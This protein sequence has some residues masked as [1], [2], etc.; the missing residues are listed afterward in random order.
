MAFFHN[1]FKAS[2]RD[3]HYCILVAFSLGSVPPTHMLETDT[4]QLPSQ[5]T[6]I[7]C[8]CMKDLGCQQ[9][10]VKQ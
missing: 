3:L 8:F 1:H 10:A 9:S 7:G 4:S 5:R 6:D 2:F